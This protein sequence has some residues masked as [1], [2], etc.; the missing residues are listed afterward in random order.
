M[1]REEDDGREEDVAGQRALEG[2]GVHHLGQEG[3]QARG[4]AGDLFVVCMWREKG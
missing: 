4:E 3:L 1:R 2:V